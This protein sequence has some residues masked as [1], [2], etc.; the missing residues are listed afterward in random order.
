MKG[1][2]EVK[3][4]TSFEVKD[5]AVSIIEYLQSK[6]AWT[7][8]N[9]SSESTSTDRESCEPHAKIICKLLKTIE[10]LQNR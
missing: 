9:D 5:F 4:R 7:N 6:I 10:F 3:I 2:T 1:Q 8:S